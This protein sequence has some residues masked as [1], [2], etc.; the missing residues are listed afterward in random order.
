MVVGGGRWSFGGIGGVLVGGGRWLI[1]K[2][3]Y[4]KIDPR[5]L[6]FKFKYCQEFIKV[7]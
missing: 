6:P 1:K 4:K 7:E 3:S 5:L 2:I